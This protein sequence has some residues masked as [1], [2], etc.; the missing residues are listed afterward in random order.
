MLGNRVFSF[1]GPRTPK[2]FGHL[3][4]TNVLT[5][6]DPERDISVAFLNTGKPLM[7]SKMVGW[8]NVL[9]VLGNRIPRDR[10]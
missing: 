7:S 4:F 1:Y 6:A 10:A 3:G 9:R 5:W 8:F 2:A